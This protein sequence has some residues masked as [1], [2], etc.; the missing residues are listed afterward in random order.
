MKHRGF[1]IVELIV[2][3]VVI[4]ALALISYVGYGNVQHRIADDAVRNDLRQAASTLEGYKNF[5]NN[6]PSNLAG[7]G[8]VPSQNVA[9][10]LYTNAPTTPTYSNLT[11]DQNAQL[12][13]N[14]C[15]AYMPVTDGTTT[16]NTVCSFA[17][18]NVH[19][20]GTKTSNVVIQGPTVAQ[21]SFVLT[22]GSVCTSA[23]NAI[24]AIFQ[25]QG[26]T[27]PVNV[28]RNQVALPSP[29]GSTSTG[30]ATAYCLSAHSS[31]FDDIAYYI[32][33]P[34]TDTLIGNCPPDSNLH[35]P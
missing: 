29:T 11:S 27:W 35:Y 25:A 2:I 4:S 8:F 23:Q 32:K 30:P 31:Q 26:G 7:T 17:G 20:S 3:I 24:I 33:S 19:V 5:A 22:C 1:T 21:S 28:P 13:L 9:L 10:S 15:N 18:N 16:Y 34:S 14:S 12:L 6:Y